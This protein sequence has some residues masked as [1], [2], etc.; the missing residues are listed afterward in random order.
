MEE[1]MYLIENLE[2][3]LNLDP[4]IVR[5]REVLKD[6]YNDNELLCLIDKY[7]IT[8]DDSLKYEIYKNS[9]FVEY[10]KLENE[11]NLIIMKINHELKSITNKGKCGI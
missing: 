4:T 9:R 1:L 10:K 6:I 5:V 11:V 3:K 7:K 2:N 8:R